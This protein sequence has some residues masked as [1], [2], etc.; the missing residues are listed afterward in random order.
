M[1]DI[2][3]RAAIRTRFHGP[4]NYKPARISA[5]RE[6]LGDTIKPQRVFVSYDHGCS[7]ADAHAIAAQ[8]FADKFLRD[9]ATIDTDSA[10]YFD[11][12]YFWT[13]N[14]TPRAN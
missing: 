8:A 1:T 9:G 2:R 14:N 11:G 4:T 3:A 6:G 7:G 10:L 12:D 13:W 5:Y